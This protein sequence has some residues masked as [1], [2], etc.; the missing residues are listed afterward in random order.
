ME[1]LHNEDEMVFLYQLIEGHANYSYA[2]Y[3]SAQAGLPEELLT[4]GKQ[5][6]AENNNNTNIV[7]SV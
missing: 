1:V 7:V 4:R 5:V 6:K 2:N 3:I